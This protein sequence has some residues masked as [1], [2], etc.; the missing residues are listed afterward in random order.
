MK[1]EKKNGKFVLVQSRAEID[2]KANPVTKTS[3]LA[4]VDKAK[5][6]KDLEQILRKLILTMNIQE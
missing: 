2:A 6:V 5:T 4:D 3:I 1:T